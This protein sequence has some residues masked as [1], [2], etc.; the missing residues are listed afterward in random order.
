MSGIVLCVLTGLEV[1]AFL[2]TP[3]FIPRTSVQVSVAL[4]SCLIFI[5]V[6][7]SSRV[8]GSY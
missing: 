5:E 1:L 4:G 7:F 2:G 3:L 6:F 8:V